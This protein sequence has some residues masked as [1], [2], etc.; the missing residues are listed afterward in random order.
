[1]HSSSSSCHLR[2]AAKGRIE[3]LQYSKVGQH[4]DSVYQKK[5]NKYPLNIMNS[6][7]KTLHYVEWSPNFEH[8]EVLHVGQPS[9]E[10]VNCRAIMWF[11]ERAEKSRRSTEVQFSICCQKGK[12]K[13]PF[14]QRPP[15][16]L[17]NLL[18]DEDPRSKHFL[19]NIRTY[20]N[21]FSFTLI[22]GKIES[23]M[24]NG[25]GPPQFILSGQNYHHIGSLLP[26]AGS[27]PKFAQLYIYDTE[28][29][30]SNRMNHFES[31]NNRSI[32]DKSLVGDFI[33][34]IDEYNVLA[35]SFRRVRDLSLQDTPSDFTLRLFRNR[36]KDPRVYNMPSS[37]EIAALIVGDFANMDVGRDIIVKKFSGDLS[38]L[39]ETHTAFIPLQYPL[40]FPY[41]EDGY[42]ENIPIREHHSGSES[43]KRIRVSL[44]EF[45]AFRIQERVCEFGNI[46][47][48]R[49]L[50]QQF[51]VD[52]YTMIEA[53]RL[54]FI[55]SNQKLVRSE[56]L[57]G[58][59]EAINRGETDPS[60]VGRRIVLPSS[61]TGGMRY[62]F[63]NCQDDMAICK[64]FSYPDLFITIT[65]NVNWLEIRD[66]LGPKGFSPSDRPDIVC[67][68][69]KVKLDEMMTDFKKNNF[70]G[71]TTARMYTIEFQ[72][73]GLPHAHI[74][75][76]LDGS[77]K[78]HNTTDI[79]NVISAELP[80][81]NL[82]PKLFKVVTSYMIHGPCGVAKLNLPC[83]KQ[84][85]C[86]KFFPKKFTAVTTIDEDGYPMY[87]R[88]NIGI[89]VE[90]N[91]IQMDNRN[92]VPYSPNLL[93]RY[94]AHV[95]TEYCN[96]SNS[97]KYLFKYVNKGPDRATMK[98]SNGTTKDGE[99]TNVDEI[100]D[101]YDCRYLSPCEAVWRTFGFDIHHR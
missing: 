53:Q 29:E 77:N 81:P 4:S 98:I 79:D 3:H 35:K 26:V 2:L 75:L 43:T 52:C 23:S 36:L 7:S 84:G 88:R 32:L 61:F 51:V 50:F 93:M 6:I 20:N 57:N 9:I 92:V 74:L 66:V 11:E 90:K 83:M 80:H 62:M 31:Y 49:R 71:Q 82:Y 21:M 25:C 1:M 33:K 40:M 28:N 56:I 68:V 72:K 8:N 45:I 65:C 76:W 5:A 87:K 37:N 10:C 17:N 100:K 16:L 91:G 44:R 27:N 30:L 89:F 34:M 38:R 58:L 12:V 59:Q 22:G 94:Q 69:F 101:Y 42:Q 54:S 14:L 97:I 67:R 85:K 95:N 96:K 13:L 78:L 41:G 63:N 47:H 70:F 19:D 64:R 60:C 55:R 46:V 99:K 48:A 24:N 18:H 15:E 39:H 73:R 86:S